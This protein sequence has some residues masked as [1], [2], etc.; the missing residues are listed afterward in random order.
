MQSLG[1]SFGGWEVHEFGVEVVGFAAAVPSFVLGV[2][3]VWRSG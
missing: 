3:G 1:Y 2:F